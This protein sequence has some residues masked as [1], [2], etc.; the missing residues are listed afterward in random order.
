V[1]GVLLRAGIPGTGAVG[2]PPQAHALVNAPWE[3]LLLLAAAAAALL[4]ISRD[5]DDGTPPALPPGDVTVLALSAAAVGLGWSHVPDATFYNLM[6]AT[7]LPTGQYGTAQQLG[8]T[9]T[10]EFTDIAVTPGAGYAYTVMAGNDGGLS[11]PS[12]P[13][14][15]TVPPA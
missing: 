8:W 1:V 15:V 3:G 4:L 14:L 11:R 10:L 7:L 9:Q 6:R 12:E 2:M 5:D 13:L